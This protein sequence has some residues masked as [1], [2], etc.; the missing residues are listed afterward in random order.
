MNRKHILQIL[1]V[2]RKGLLNTLRD[3][4]GAS[5]RLRT[6]TRLPPVLYFVKSD[7]LS[8]LTSFFNLSLQLNISRSADFFAYMVQPRGKLLRQR[9]PSVTSC[10]K[11]PFNHLQTASAAI[12]Q[13]D[14]R[15]TA[16]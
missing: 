5:H 9:V 6:L 12:Q 8:F 16:I 14:L 4:V 1:E 15:S 2:L 11:T 3:G 10:L 13:A 7:T